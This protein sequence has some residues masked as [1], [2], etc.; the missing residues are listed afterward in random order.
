M[1]SVAFVR[2]YSCSLGSW[3]DGH[4]SPCACLQPKAE[5]A[6]CELPRLAQLNMLD[7]SGDEAAFVRKEQARCTSHGEPNV[8]DNAPMVW[9]DKISSFKTT[10]GVETTE[11]K[12]VPSISLQLTVLHVGTC[13]SIR[14][15][16]RT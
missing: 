1:W 3:K 4:Y 6:S 12:V 15:R 14:P 11:E 8:D 7:E 13:H 9:P 2:L 10:N 16:P 5:E